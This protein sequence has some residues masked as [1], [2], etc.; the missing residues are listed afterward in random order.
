MSGKIVYRAES[1]RA[2]F[3]IEFPPSS[4]KETQFQQRLEPI[5]KDGVNCFSRDY[6]LKI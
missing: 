3:E 4:N 5:Y 2:D 1:L 6:I